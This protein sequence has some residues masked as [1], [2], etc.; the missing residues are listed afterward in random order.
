[1][2][3]GAL[4]LA[5]PI[6]YSRLGYEIRSRTR[7]WAPLTARTLAGRTVMVTGATSGIGRAVATTFARLGARLF[8]VGRSPERTEQ[9]RDDIVAAVDGADV[10]VLIADLSD[11]DAIRAAAAEFR[12]R[13]TT[14]DVLVHNAGALLNE[15]TLTPDGLEVTVATHVLGPFTLTRE[16]LEPLGRSADARVITVSSGGMYT[17]KLDVDR[18]VM[19]PDDYRGPVAYARAKRAQVV[20]NQLWPVRAPGI[21]FH[22]MHP[23]WAATPGVA[24][25]LPAFNRV[26]KPLL[27]SPDQ[28][29]DTIIWLATT[30]LPPRSNGQFWFDRRMRS[31]QRLPWSGAHAEERARLWEWA[32]RASSD[33]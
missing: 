6:G 14:L 5:F 7:H 13:Q 17:E 28:G 25:S 32:E 4:E 1:M 2:V 3:D 23:G 22:A 9:A 18:L 29:A 8:I 31:D 21:G 15:Y 24:D 30:E 11:L 12:S 20:L 27:R 26:M 16:L 19:G 33:P 10:S